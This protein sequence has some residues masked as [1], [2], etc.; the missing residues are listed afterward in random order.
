GYPINP[1]AVL[2]LVYFIIPPTCWTNITAAPRSS[3]T[4]LRTRCGIIRFHASSIC[5]SRPAPM[6]RSKVPLPFNGPYAAG[7]HWHWQLGWRKGARLLDLL[8]AGSRAEATGTE[9]RSHPGVG[10]QSP[11]FCLPFAGSSN[12][13]FFPSWQV[14]QRYVGFSTRR[15]RRRKRKQR[16][17]AIPERVIG[18]VRARKRSYCRSQGTVVLPCFSL[19]GGP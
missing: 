10:T 17:V 18:L 19:D 12:S 2:L 6:I 16:P 1:I 3:F 9:G 5:V 15:C 4:E 7:V 11:L 13:P 14:I 8:P